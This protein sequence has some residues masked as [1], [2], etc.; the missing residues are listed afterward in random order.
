[1]DNSK[2]RAPEDVCRNRSTRV[3]CGKSWHFSAGSGVD[4]FD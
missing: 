4:I 3:D 1:M 2:A